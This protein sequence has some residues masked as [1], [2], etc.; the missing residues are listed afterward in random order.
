MHVFYRAKWM[1]GGVIRANCQ[2]SHA[3]LVMANY[4]WQLMLMRAG[5]HRQTHPDKITPF[6]S[7]FLKAE[8]YPAIST[9]PEVRARH[10]S[11]HT[12]QELSGTLSVSQST[13]LLLLSRSLTIA[14]K[15]LIPQCR[16][17]QANLLSLTPLAPLG[18]SQCVGSDMGSL[19]FWVVMHGSNN[20]LLVA[21]CRL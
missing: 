7:V 11:C 10:C 5:R 6:I 19:L 20:A 1:S 12:S 8:H 18:S 15:D 16:F 21:A 14:L 17:V 2:I 4:N 13:R 3:S 9:H